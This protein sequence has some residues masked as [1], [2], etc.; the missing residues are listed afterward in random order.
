MARRE[1]DRPR[2]DLD[3]A[4]GG[5][6]NDLLADRGVPTEN[7]VAD[8]DAVERAIVYLQSKKPEFVDV[9]KAVI[10]HDESQVGYAARTGTPSGTVK[11]QLSRAK[12]V[13]LAA[14][15]TGKLAL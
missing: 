5:A 4:F 8:L 15:E 14:Y 11:S 7:I 9:F 1:Q 13:L 2:A 12:A 3:L 10:I 6:A